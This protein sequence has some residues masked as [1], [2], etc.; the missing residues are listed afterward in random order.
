MNAY[1]SL[2]GRLLLAAI[3]LQSGLNK[4]ISPDETAQAMQAVGLSPLFLWPTI[5]LEIVGSV[6][7]VLGWY[8]R[9]AAFL[10]A[11]FTV[12]AGLYFHANFLDT[13][14]MNHFMKNLAIVGGLLTLTANGPGRISLSSRF[15]TLPPSGH[16]L[17]SR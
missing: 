4:A 10:L 2:A 11:V 5:A 6:A 8:S 1:L 17:P 3:F 12:L 16:P 14:Q 7:L 13:N 9:P 15:F